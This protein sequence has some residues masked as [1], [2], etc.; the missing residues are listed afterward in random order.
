MGL[1]WA[2]T[3]FLGQ[4]QGLLVVG[5]G[6]GDIRGLALRR[7]LTEE[8]Q[9]DG[10]LVYVAPVGEMLQGDQR[11]LEGRQRLP[12]GRACRRRRT[13]LTAVGHG[14]FPYLPPESVVGEPFDLISL[15]IGKG[16]L[17]RCDDLGMERAP[18]LLE[19]T[20]VGHLVGECVLEGVFPLGKEPRLVEKFGRL[21]VGQATM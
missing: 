14:L 18:P 7:D 1:E 12:R 17:K 15:S 16:R 3:E 13:S 2:H 6:M 9:V 20:P 21:Q 4:S 8:P 10:L 19:Q 11:L 5:F